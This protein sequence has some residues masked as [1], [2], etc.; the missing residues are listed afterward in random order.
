[1]ITIQVEKM[2]AM[3]SEQTRFK[4]LSENQLEQ[5]RQPT[6]PI[7]LT[8]YLYKKNPKRQEQDVFT[9]FDKD[10]RRLVYFCFRATALSLTP[11]CRRTFAIALD[12]A[13]TYKFKRDHLK[14]WREI[15]NNIQKFIKQ[16]HRLSFND[17]KGSSLQ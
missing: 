12:T 5:R 10:N 1:M 15:E 11:N 16:I 7:G 6:A 14:N 2:Q 8:H 4:F 17:A 9:G 13:L 3:I